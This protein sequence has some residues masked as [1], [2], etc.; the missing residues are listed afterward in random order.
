MVL[1]R[2]PVLTFLDGDKTLMFGMII[3]LWLAQCTPNTT[4]WG[5]NPQ[6]GVQSEYEL[7]IDRCQ[8]SRFKVTV[9]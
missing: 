9:M 4:E 7:F 5:I 2:F 6:G 8:K 3:Q 1:F